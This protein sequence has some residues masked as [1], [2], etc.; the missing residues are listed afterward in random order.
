VLEPPNAPAQQSLD[1]QRL[2]LRIEFGAAAGESEV[3]A[4]RWAFDLFR[5]SWGW[6]AEILEV[7]PFD[8]VG[9]QILGPIL[10]FET[11]RFRGELSAALRLR[12]RQLSGSAH[13]DRG[14]AW[15]SVD[16]ER[17]WRLVGRTRDCL[18]VDRL[19]ALATNASR[20]AGILPGLPTRSPMM[21]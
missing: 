17:A 10:F 7:A 20:F 8:E 14:P 5:A 3:V 16:E 21:G 9:Q 15:R 12:R 18:H 4:D 19:C 2:V 11:A 13:G 6:R 1:G